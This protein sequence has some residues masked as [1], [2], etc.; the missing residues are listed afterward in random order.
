[1]KKFYKYTLLLLAAFLFA[2]L[3][4]V[5]DDDVNPADPINPLD[6]LGFSKKVTPDPNKDNAYNITLTAF[7]TGSSVSETSN[8]TPAADIVLVLDISGSMN[9][10]LKGDEISWNQ[11]QQNT[12]YYMVMGNN[13]YYFR[14]TGN[15]SGRYSGYNF[16]SNTDNHSYTHSNSSTE[17]FYRV[18]TT[19]R[20]MAMKTAAQ[21][22]VQTVF[23]RNPTG[24]KDRKHRVG[25]VTFSS[26]ATN[27]TSL[28]ELTTQQVT[29]NIKNTINNLT[30]SGSTNSGAGMQ[31]A[32]NMLNAN[33]VRNDGRS[34]I[35][36]F[37]TDGQ[38]ASS[39]EFTPSIART[40]VYYADQIKT[41]TTTL[42]DTDGN[43]IQQDGADIILQPKVYSVGLL[44]SETYGTNT[45]NIRR[46]MHYVS[47]NYKTGIPTGG[48]YEFAANYTGA[49]NQDT[50]VTVTTPGGAEAP[51]GF[52]QLSDGS[53]E[54]LNTIFQN[55]ASSSST[56]PTIPLQLKSTDV[57]AVDVI[58]KKFKL[59]EGASADDIQVKVAKFT[60]IDN[61]GTYTEGQLSRLENYQFATPST[62]AD[63]RN[64]TSLGEDTVAAAYQKVN[65]VWTEITPYA[66]VTT[67]DGEQVISVQGFNYSANWCGF[68]EHKNPNGT[69]TYIPHGYELVIIIPIEVSASNPGGATVETNGPGSGIKIYDDQGHLAYDV[70]FPLPSVTL[71]NII[72]RKYGLL[73]ENEGASFCL[74]KLKQVGSNWVVDDDV[75]KYYVVVVAKDND[76]TTFDFVQVKLQQP[77]RYRVTETDWGW[78]YNCTADLTN[79][80]ENDANDPNR[81]LVP[82]AKDTNEKGQPYIDRDVSGDTEQTITLPDGANKLAGAVYDFKNE[83]KQ[84]EKRN[85]SEAYKRN[86]F[87]TVY[88]PVEN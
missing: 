41:L 14:K 12:D 63:A 43:A 1:M 83:S 42:T 78:S 7:T 40:A 55:I 61:T 5:A 79:L 80:E 49:A 11:M 2:P 76:P 88:N 59:P 62:Y 38:P 36:V 51:H 31:N 39:W 33:N 37:F 28:T 29:T 4:V 50:T 86:E 8:I 47:S 18:T 19:T 26:S 30:A 87:H 60:G 15:N 16:G 82:K 6:G 72:I 67:E 53:A 56:A 34:K 23:D 46:F 44:F 13:T 32:Y 20:L 9:D 45:W 66:T 85:Y 65:N 35:A 10:P 70:S 69:I 22:F 24:S 68:D 74:E 77:G 64:V 25:I 84:L 75:D 71:P 27:T 57:V 3:A 81:T 48:S 21:N 73:Y 17:T 58:S 54:S 52:Y